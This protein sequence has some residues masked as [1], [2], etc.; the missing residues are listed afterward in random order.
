MTD[1][2]EGNIISRVH[3]D[4]SDGRVIFERL[5]DVEPILDD[6]KRLEGESQ[7]RKADFRHIATIPNVI[8][9]KWIAEEGAPVLAMSS[10]EFAAFIRRKLNDPDYRYLRTAPKVR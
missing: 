3:R 7:S 6:N 5:Q 2:S 8:I 10:H 4:R 9:E 1:L